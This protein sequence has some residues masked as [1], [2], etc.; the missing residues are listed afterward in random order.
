M[1]HCLN[2]GHNIAAHTDET[3]N[4]KCKACVNCGRG[5]SMPDQCDKIRDIY[6]YNMLKEMKCGK[7]NYT[8]N[9]KGWDSD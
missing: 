3:P 9:C 2:C 7:E 5:G 4:S 1:S 6:D 8:C